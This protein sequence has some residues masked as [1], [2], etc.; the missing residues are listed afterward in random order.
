MVVNDLCRMLLEAI[1]LGDQMLASGYPP[2]ALCLLPILIGVFSTV[3]F[4]SQWTYV[5]VESVI[6]IETD[7]GMVFP[8]VADFSK[9]KP[10]NPLA[11]M[12]PEAEFAVS[13]PEK[14][15]DVATSGDKVHM[16]DAVGPYLRFH[17]KR[18]GTGFVSVKRARQPR[19]IEFEEK[20]VRPWT[21]VTKHTFEFVDRSAEVNSGAPAPKVGMKKGRTEVFFGFS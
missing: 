20:K 12:E 18:I 14:G 3:L 7:V 16:K 4:A 6:I 1:P 10:W 13:I 17:G 5:C 19:E 15:S 9:W 8:L 21:S 11:V 2:W